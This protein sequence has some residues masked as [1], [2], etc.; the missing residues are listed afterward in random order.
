[1]I[2]MPDIQRTRLLDD[3]E[4]FSRQDLP[5]GGK[6]GQLGQPAEKLVFPPL[7]LPESGSPLIDRP[8]FAVP[9]A[10][11]AV[12]KIPPEVPAS[13]PGGF[14]LGGNSVLARLKREAQSAQQEAQR[15]DQMDNAR[16]QQ[17]SACMN[18]AY[19]YFDDLIKQLNIVKPAVP[20]EY[21]FFGNLLFSGMRWMEGGADFRMMPS[22]TEDRL[23]ETVT[24]RLRIASPNVIQVERQAHQVETLTRHLHDYNIFFDVYETR[25]IR[26][27]VQHARFSIP[28]EI[29]AGFLLKADY[30][31]GDLVLRTRNIDRF[32]TM[33][34]RLGMSDLNHD[35]LDEFSRLILGEEN[36][37][38]KMFRRTA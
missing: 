24:L 34:F 29:K 7:S 26:N 27:Q 5:S 16:A 30:A 11:P 9:Q 33:E 13:T 23:Y 3:I 35:T 14:A 12:V 19:H 38:L 22:T 6:T 2:E 37:F 17:L 32:G 4:A 1:M 18:D 21:T 28:C 8:S 15:R 31:A 36:R 20:R 25:N 10:T